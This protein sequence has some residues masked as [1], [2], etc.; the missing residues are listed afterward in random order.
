MQST[1]QEVVHMPSFTSMQALRITSAIAS[2]SLPERRTLLSEGE[3][4][5]VGIGG[6]QCLQQLGR[7]P[8]ICLLKGQMGGLARDGLDR[9]ETERRRGEYVGDPAIHLGIKLFRRNDRVQ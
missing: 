4:P 9:P 7:S 2:L 8:L 1:G 6:I 3:N 5:L